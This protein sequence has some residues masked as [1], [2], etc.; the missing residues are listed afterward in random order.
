MNTTSTLR[1]ITSGSTFE[2][3]VQSVKDNGVEAFWKDYNTNSSLVRY[4]IEKIGYVPGFLD[5]FHQSEFN[6]Q[7]RILY[8]LRNGKCVWSSSMHLKMIH[9]TASNWKIVKEW[10]EGPH[11]NWDLPYCNGESGMPSQ[12]FGIMAGTFLHTIARRHDS[13]HIIF[14]IIDAQTL[15]L[16]AIQHG[17]DRVLEII[18]R[19]QN[20]SPKFDKTFYDFTRLIQEWDSVQDLPITWALNLVGS[21]RCKED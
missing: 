2:E 15:T 18:D 9:D 14:P 13:S 19:V 1:P 10:K 8:M 17:E 7:K 5:Y 4:Q 11:G 20:S 3:Y 12:T 16:L 6:L 21:H